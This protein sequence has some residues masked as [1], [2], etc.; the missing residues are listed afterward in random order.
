MPVPPVI[1][2]S[3]SPSKSSALPITFNVTFAVLITLSAFVSSPI[4]STVVALV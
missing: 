1:V 4:M 3:T 2:V